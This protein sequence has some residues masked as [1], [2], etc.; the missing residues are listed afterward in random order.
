MAVGKE[1]GELQRFIVDDDFKFIS[2]N[3]L[4]A[5]R[6]PIEC[7]V[8]FDQNLPRSFVGRSLQVLD[9]AFS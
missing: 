8:R 6:I 7:W 4:N 1:V 3:G 2:E 5:V 9:N